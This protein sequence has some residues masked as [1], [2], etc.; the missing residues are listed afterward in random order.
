MMKLKGFAAYTKARSKQ[1]IR[2]SPAL[3]SLASGILA[4]SSRNYLVSTLFAAFPSISLR[5]VLPVAPLLL[6]V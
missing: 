3:P 5:L 2:F 6:D 4:T 1:Q